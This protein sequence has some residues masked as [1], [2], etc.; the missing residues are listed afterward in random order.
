MKSEPVFLALKYTVSIPWWGLLDSPGKMSNFQ[1]FSGVR[2]RNKFFRGDNETHWGWFEDSARWTD[3]YVVLRSS[4][5]V[6]SLRKGVLKNFTK[7]TGKHLCQSLFFNKVAGLRHRCFPVN[8]VKFLTTTFL[9]NSS[10]Q[11]L[12]SFHFPGDQELK[13]KRIYFVNCRDWSPTT[14]SVIMYL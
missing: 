14:H 9:Q 3:K 1:T 13:Q 10:G 6:C 11:L 4:H 2:T 8:F 5:K 7:F 12:L